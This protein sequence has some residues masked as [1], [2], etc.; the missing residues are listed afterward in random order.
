MASDAAFVDWTN[1]RT[2]SH[3]YKLRHEFDGEIQE[4]TRETRQ[5]YDVSVRLNTATIVSDGEDSVL[6]VP[7]SARWRDD[8][9]QT[10][11][12][13]LIYSTHENEP[14]ISAI[15]AGV[16][17]LLDRWVEREVPVG[18]SPEFCYP[19]SDVRWPPEPESTDA[20]ARQVQAVAGGAT[21]T[22]PVAAA[23]APAAAAT[24]APAASATAAPPAAPM[25]PA[26]AADATLAATAAAA[27][28]VE[29]TEPE[30]RAGGETPGA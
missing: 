11:A 13:L 12:A 8:L 5:N 23:T 29:T 3:W 25:T 17:E 27:T 22:A 20:T 28:P 21:P 24:A 19:Q 30:Q 6:R 7:V 26:A 10:I 15:A 1:L 2:Q 14:R 4:A 16:A 9:E 18:A